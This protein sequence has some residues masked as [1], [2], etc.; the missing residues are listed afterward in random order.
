MHFI[1]SIWCYLSTQT[2][3]LYWQNALGSERG[4]SRSRGYRG[5]FA[6]A[7]YNFAAGVWHPWK[8]GKNHAFHWPD[9]SLAMLL[10]I[11]TWT[12]VDSRYS[13]YSPT[14]VNWWPDALG[15]PRSILQG[16]SCTAHVAASQ[17]LNYS[18]VVGGTLFYR[19]LCWCWAGPRVWRTYR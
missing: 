11:D 14:R 5:G 13:E 7:V 16:P 19:L 4:L 6:V 9:N 8:V 12:K 3:R 15:S 10:L 1:L 2:W 17:W 18:R